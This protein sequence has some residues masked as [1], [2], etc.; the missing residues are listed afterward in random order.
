MHLLRHG[1]VHNPRACSTAG[2]PATTSPSSGQQMAQRVADTIG[3]R[4]ITHVVASPL[5]RAQETARPLAL[6]RGLEIVTDARVIESTNVFE[7]RR[8]SV[9]DGIS[10]ARRPGGTCGTRSG[11]R[12]ASPTRRSW[13]A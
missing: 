4:D 1:E 5:E 11:R 10:S 13:P 7:G 2:C 9:G 3:D 8:F 6:A 12:G